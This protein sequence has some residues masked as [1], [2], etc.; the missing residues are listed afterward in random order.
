[1]ATEIEVRPGT[2]VKCSD[3]HKGF[4]LI[5]RRAN[6]AALIFVPALRTWR[7]VEAT[8]FNRREE[9]HSHELQ[10]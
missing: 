1:M 2:E 9:R 7:W 8:R 4:V 6:N 10:P 3:G 5:L